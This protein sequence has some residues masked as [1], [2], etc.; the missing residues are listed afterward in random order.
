MPFQ[1]P[2]IRQSNALG[3]INDIRQQRTQNA[4]ADRQLALTE[5][6]QR[7]QQQ[8][9]D[10]EQAAQARAQMIE[11]TKGVLGALARV[12][13][14]Q[15]QQAFTQLASELPPEFVQRMAANPEAFTDQNIALALNRFGTLTQEQLAG[16]ERRMAEAKAKPEMVVTFGADG[17][18]PVRRAFNPYG[19]ELAA[20]VT[21]APD[22]GALMSDRRAA[23]GQALTARGQNMADARARENA[24]I[25]RQGLLAPKPGEDAEGPGFFSF[26]RASGRMIRVPGVSPAGTTAAA[27]EKAARIMSVQ[28][29]LDVVQQAI[30]HPGRETATGASGRFDPRNYAPGT[31]AT[32]FQV[33][34]DQ[35][36]GA[37]FL[38]AFETLRG[39]GQITEVEGT[40]ATNAIARL[41][42]SQS[43]EEFLKA[44]KELQGVMGKGY[45]RLSGRPYTPS[46][47]APAASEPGVV[48]WEDM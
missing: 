43:D 14:A 21:D 36:N 4:L 40:K 31:D 44:L 18:T 9:F 22:A 23:A 17:R 3:M 45:A 20:G 35:I 30:N 34:L 7:R 24:A 29:Q 32:N 28:Q 47:D 38:Q 26:D 13:Q 12:P 15:R 25:A 11:T 33:I 42:R 19:P 37:A 46:R 39:G 1:M 10:T 27:N 6:A 2:E 5:G 48:N 16:D 41:N 8:Q